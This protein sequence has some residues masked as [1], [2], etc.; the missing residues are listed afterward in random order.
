MPRS[1]EPEAKIPLLHELFEILCYW[2]ANLFVFLYWVGLCKLM[3]ISPEVSAE[4]ARQIEFLTYPVAFLG[5]LF[6]KLMLDDFRDNENVPGWKIL[7][8][9]SPIGFFVIIVA[10]L[11]IMF[12]MILWVPYKLFQNVFR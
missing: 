11:L 5:W 1:F 8:W 6:I 2:T 9:T 10:M 3:A 12:A 4:S 7:C